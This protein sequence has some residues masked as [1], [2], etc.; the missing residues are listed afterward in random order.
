[1]LNKVFII[2]KEKPIKNTEVYWKNLVEMLWKRI[3]KKEKWKI[4][5]IVLNGKVK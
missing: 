3:S 1:M 5:L 4:V 2:R